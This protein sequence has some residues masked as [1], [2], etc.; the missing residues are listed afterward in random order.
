MAARL[1]LENKVSWRAHAEDYAD[2][3]VCVITGAGSYVNTTHR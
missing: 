3:Q 1:R 2:K